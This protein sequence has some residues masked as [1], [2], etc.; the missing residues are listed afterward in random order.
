MGIQEISRFEVWVAL[1]DQPGS[2][3]QLLL[4]LHNSICLACICLA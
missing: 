4:L 1:D 3:L 2:C